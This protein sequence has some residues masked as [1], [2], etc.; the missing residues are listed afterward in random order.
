M[1][2]RIAIIEEIILAH[3]LRNVKH[4]NVALHRNQNWPKSMFAS[5]DGNHWVI[6]LAYILR[7]ITHMDIV[8]LTLD[9]DHQGGDL[10]MIIVGAWSLI[11]G[12]RSAIFGLQSSGWRSS[13]CSHRGR[14]SECSI[15][16]ATVGVRSMSADG[17]YWSEIFGW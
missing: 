3:I 14:S 17:S 12:H 9:C 8:S 13:D 11:H 7:Y 15:R 1:W 10:R 4:V 6:I 16:M 2:F 5:S